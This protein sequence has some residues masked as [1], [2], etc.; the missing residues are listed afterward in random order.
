MGRIARA[1]G[2]VDHHGNPELFGKQ[3]GFTAH[4]SILLCAV[5]VWMQCVAMTTQGAD[6]DAVVGQHLLK[7][8]ERSGIFEHRKFAVSVTWIVSRGEFDGIDSERDEF[9]KNGGQRKLRQQG[10]KD[11]NAHKAFCLLES[12]GSFYRSCLMLPLM[13]LEEITCA[14]FESLHSSFFFLC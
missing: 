13:P 2:E 8:S 11:S 5:L 12:S 7:L 9:L 4:I 1:S 3:D 10:S 6:T 14:T